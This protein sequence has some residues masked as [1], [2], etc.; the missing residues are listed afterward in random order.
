MQAFLTFIESII[1]P[2]Q[3]PVFTVQMLVLSAVALVLI[4]LIFYTT[5]DVF[6]RSDSFVF[7]LF[8][9]LLVVL[10]PVVGFL[11]YLLIRPAQTKKERQLFAELRALHKEVTALK[12]AQTGTKKPTAKKTSTK[13]K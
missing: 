4:F 9:L 3:N 12:A 11:L 5:K 8:S 6:V 13:K 10:F 2:S 7:M 1:L